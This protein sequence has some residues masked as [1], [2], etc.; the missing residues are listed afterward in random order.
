[1]GSAEPDH[2]TPSGDEPSEFEDLPED[3]QIR[4]IAQALAILTEKGYEPISPELLSE[5]MGPE[6]LR[7]LA[8]NIDVSSSLTDEQLVTIAENIPDEALHQALSETM[9]NDSSPDSSSQ[10]D[11]PIM[12]R[13]VETAILERPQA[14]LYAIALV[15]MMTA[16]YMSN[17]LTALA[18][19][20][21]LVFTVVHYGRR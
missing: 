8:D 15:M 12:T 7:L 21:I 16:F 4:A 18:G 19:S 6:Q 14:T 13:A 11:T 5:A 10:Q 20:V 2:I 9:E 17:P 3:I 1:M